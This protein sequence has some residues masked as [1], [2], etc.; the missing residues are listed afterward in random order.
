MTKLDTARAALQDP[1]VL[2]LMR[3]DPDFA[4]YFDADG[5]LT[6]DPSR[7]DS[8]WDRFKQELSF[9]LDRLRA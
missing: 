8:R 1:E 5:N 6:V 2:A 7:P 4:E 3:Q 9:R